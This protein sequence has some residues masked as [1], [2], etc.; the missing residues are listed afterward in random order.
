M[1][2]AFSQQRW[3]RTRQDYA[4]WWAGESDRPMV[5]VT[6]T[7]R[8]PE[9]NAP[10]RNH[11]GRTAAYDLDRASAEE[12]VD[13]EDHFL[14]G[15]EFRA[16]GFPQT[17]LDYGPGVLAVFLG[18]R[19]EI[20]RQ[21]VWFHPPAGGEDTPPGEMNLQLRPDHPWLERI[22]AIISAARE[23]W[24]SLVQVGMT[25]LGGAVDV[26][27]TF[28]P[29]EKL[30]LDLYDHP[31]DVERLTWQVHEAWFA[32]WD[33]LNALL[34]P[35]NPGYTAWAGI[36]SPRPHYMFQ[37]DFA[38]M[39]GPEMFERFVLPELSASF[40]RVEHAFYHLDGVG[41]LPHLDMLLADENL[42]GIQ[43]VP[44]DGQKPCGEW[45]DVYRRIQDAGK[46][47]QFF[48]PIGDLEK[49]VDDLGSPAGIVTGLQQ[50]SPQEYDR[51]APVLERL[52]VPGDLL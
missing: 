33:R 10:R 47:I 30:L 44:G 43:W 48:G 45:P 23:R 26:I 3:D 25:D 14:A 7:G 41:Q 51:A 9:R 19:G 20:T 12:I 1:S 2:I 8:D 36:F 28:R 11:R 22:E 6:V 29:G 42:R 52:G 24:G 40:A 13:S 37:C 34:Q 35:T 17:W 46:L 5:P 27:S 4:A 38:Y 49:L 16:D 31:A 32:V 18:A 15:L 50:L 21:T 39:I